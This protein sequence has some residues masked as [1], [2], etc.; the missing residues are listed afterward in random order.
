MN[1]TI[2]TRTGLLTGLS[3][4]LYTLVLQRL[5]VAAQS[6]LVLFQFLLLFVGVLVSC[7]LLFRFYAGI[8]FLDAFTHCAKT[9]AMVIIVVIIGNAGLFFIFSPKGTPLAQ[10]TFMIMKTVFS[11]ALSGL[12]SAFFTSYIFHTFTKK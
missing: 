7:F 12:L 10:L 9:V 11:Y 1:K 8:R 2:S 4:L 5:G 3:V 6:P